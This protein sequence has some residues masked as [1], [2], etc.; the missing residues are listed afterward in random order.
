[1]C[2]FLID[3]FL[4]II[5]GL[6]A[7]LVIGLIFYLHQ[8]RRELLNSF[9][10]YNIRWSEYSVNLKDRINK[11]IQNK[12]RITESDLTVSY[13]SLYN[14]MFNSPYKT[15]CRDFLNNKDFE[16]FSNLYKYLYETAP[17]VFDLAY[18]RSEQNLDEASLLEDIDRHIDDFQAYLL[19]DI[20]EPEL[21]QV[22]EI[23]KGLFSTKG[24]I[25]RS[26]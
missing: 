12:E 9:A 18:H 17:D 6:I 3:F 7:S 24:N 4:A 21:P 22:S 1:M 15:S 11:L 8:N 13:L 23:I 10:D 16:L 26:N 2:D 5:T 25:K 19:T 14:I 20:T